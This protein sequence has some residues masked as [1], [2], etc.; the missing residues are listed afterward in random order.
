MCWLQQ[1]PEHRCDMV[2]MRGVSREECCSTGRLDT[3][4]S[5]TSLPINEVSLLGFLGIVSC[6][7]CKGTYPCIWSKILAGLVVSAD[8]QMC[9]SQR[10]ILTWILCTKSLLT[11]THSKE[12]SVLWVDPL[13]WPARSRFGNVFFENSPASLKSTDLYQMFSFIFL[14]CCGKRWLL[15]NVARYA[16]ICDFYDLRFIEVDWIASTHKD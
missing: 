8:V 6:K 16:S 13:K 2:L 9:W 3:A 1:G 10:K 11:L 15:V 12:H 14:G 4:W 7:P 5:N